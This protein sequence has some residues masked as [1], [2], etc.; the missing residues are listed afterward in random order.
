MH[1]NF[2]KNVNNPIKYNHR[3]ILD[4]LQVLNNPTQ[5]GPAFLRSQSITLYDLQ[6]RAKVVDES[7]GSLR[8]RKLNDLHD[9]A[10]LHRRDFVIK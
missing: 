1:K 8:R 9:S 10:K 4:P 7:P 3:E 5:P 2:T 6:R